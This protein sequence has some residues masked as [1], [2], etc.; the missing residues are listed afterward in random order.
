MGKIFTDTGFEVT[1]LVDNKKTIFVET[2]A[3]AVKLTERAGYFYTILDA[4]KNII[5]FGIPK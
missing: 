2:K 1:K 4:N 3:E 5:G